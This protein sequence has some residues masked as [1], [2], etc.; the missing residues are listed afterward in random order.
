MDKIQPVKGMTFILNAAIHVNTTRLAGMSLNS[1]LRIDHTQFIYILCDGEFIAGHYSNDG[2][3]RVTGLPTFR[4]TASV[5]MRDLA[6]NGHYNGI[7]CAMALQY[8]TCKL[9]LTRL[10]PAIDHGMKRDCHKVLPKI[11]AMA[12]AFCDLPVRYDRS[13]QAIFYS[14][15]GIRAS[16]LSNKF[17]FM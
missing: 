11:V 10:K 4:A 14:F 3:F 8:A 6:F 5:I 13:H 7:F 12:Y 2:K 9:L 1:S 16:K 15:T 17:A